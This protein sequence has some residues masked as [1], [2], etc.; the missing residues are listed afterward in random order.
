M[1]ETG[2][3][4]IDEEAQDL[5]EAIGPTCIL[6]PS[7]WPETFC[8]TLSFAF[9]LGVP[10]VVFDLGAQRERVEAA[11]FGFVLPYGL[12]DDVKA[13]NDRLIG[14]PYGETTRPK[15]ARGLLYPNVLA[16]YYELAAT[17]DHRERAVDGLPPVAG[18]SHSL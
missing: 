17:R 3:Y 11:G 7:I 13:L 14:L 1:N 9:A 5:I 18:S 4:A 12:T 10:P 8:Y 16:D 15:R 2:R 6:L